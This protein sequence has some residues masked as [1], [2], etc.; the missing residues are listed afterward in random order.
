MPDGVFGIEVTSEN[1]RC[2]V[3]EVKEVG[4]RNYVIGWFVDGGKF[5]GER[6]FEVDSDASVFEGR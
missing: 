6:V 4:F 2:A 1:G 3:E 5:Y